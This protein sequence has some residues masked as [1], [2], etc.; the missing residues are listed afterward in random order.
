MTHLTIWGLIARITINFTIIIVIP[1]TACW[2]YVNNIWYWLSDYL[3]SKLIILP[4][5]IT[6]LS[7]RMMEYSFCVYII[8]LSFLVLFCNTLYSYVNYIKEGEKKTN[9]G[10][11]VG[12]LY[13]LWVILALGA[14]IYIVIWFNNVKNFIE[15]V[16]YLTNPDSFEEQFT[17]FVKYTGHFTLVLYIAFIF[18]D[19]FQYLS[20]K[21]RS[22]LEGNLSFQQLWFVDIATLFGVLTINYITFKADITTLDTPLNVFLCGATGMQVILS[23][24]VFF[25]IFTLYNISVYTSQNS[26]N[27]IVASID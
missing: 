12:L 7:A 23:Q 20:V 10:K 25:F 27:R 26:C 14:A 8:L 6:R 24:F 13:P 15:A 5:E 4:G 18:I 3:R 22:K 21:N 19:F 9:K 16:N 2:L 1:A 17:T 11:I